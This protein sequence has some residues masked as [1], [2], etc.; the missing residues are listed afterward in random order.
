MVGAS[1]RYPGEGLRKNHLPLPWT[2]QRFW[3]DGVLR[4]MD[5]VRW[6]LVA[7]AAGDGAKAGGAA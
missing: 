7:V 3:N 5:N 1:E 2:I 4:G 6:H